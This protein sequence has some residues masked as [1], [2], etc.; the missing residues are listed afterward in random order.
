[1]QQVSILSKEIS[2]CMCF[3]QN[4]EKLTKST[5]NYHPNNP[6][7]FLSFL[8][9]SCRLLVSILLRVYLMLV[10]IGNGYKG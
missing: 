4:V 8:H 10:L 9:Q 6:L 1:M 5:A 2:I 7:S 3:D